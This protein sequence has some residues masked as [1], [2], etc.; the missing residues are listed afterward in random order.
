MTSQ[1]RPVSVAMVLF[2]MAALTCRAA[3]QYHYSLNAQ[4]TPSAPMDLG[5]FPAGA[6][7]TIQATGTIS[8]GSTWNTYA[9]GSLASADTNSTYAYVNAGATNYP[10]TYGG[11][12]INHF[13]G[14]GAN[15]DVV[16][17][18]FG[19]A[20]VQSTDTTNAGAVRMGTVIG[21]FSDPGSRSNLFVVGAASAITIP[22]GGAHIFLSVC[23]SHYSAASG[24]YSVTVTADPVIKGLAPSSIDAGSSGFTLK[25]KGLNF[26]DQSYVQWN[27]SS[28][29]TTFISS[30]ELDAAIAANLIYTSGKAK[31]QVLNP[32]GSLSPAKTFN[33]LLTSLRLT[34]PVLQRNGSTISVAVNFQNSGHYAAQ[35]IQVT[36]ATLNKVKTTSTLPAPV[37]TLQPGQTGGLVLDFPGSAGTSGQVVALRVG[38]KFTGGT[39]SLSTTVVLP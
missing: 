24:Y 18:T 29:P 6:V 37:G 31:V 15:F 38:G 39:F 22:S 11:D 27:G 20:G 9:D 4:T 25:V 16:S 36:Q 12:G 14:G 1:R 2:L 34:K 7:V 26:F 23:D 30:K 8:L 10:T 35:S 21:S 13:G 5:A 17:G 28:L 3:A 33:I 19:P 32:D